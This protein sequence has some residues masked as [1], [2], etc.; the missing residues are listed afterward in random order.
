[1]KEYHKQPPR[2]RSASPLPLCWRAAAP[3]G[4]LIDPPDASWRFSVTSG[5]ALGVGTR[6][7][8]LHRA[9]NLLGRSTPAAPV[10]PD[11]DLSP[12]D[13]D[14]RV[15]RRHAE[16]ACRPGATEVTDLGSAN[17]TYRNG[18]RLEPGRAVLLRDGDR[19]TFGA[20]I[21]VYLADAPWPDG[22]LAEWTDHDP[23]TAESA[24]PHDPS[25][26]LFGHRGVVPREAAP[27]APPKRGLRLPLPPW[28]WRRRH[29]D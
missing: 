21:A 18:T 19:L 27:T 8:P 11:L 1:V 2:D 7:L 4:A 20:V 3:E 17:G 10:A 12:D 22:L 25:M 6:I 28:T 16:L 24:A 23:L 15:S 14:R 29:R 26:T 13:A 5:P 9:V